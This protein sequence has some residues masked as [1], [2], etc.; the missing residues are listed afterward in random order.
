VDPEIVGAPSASTSTV[1]AAELEVQPFASTVVTL[2]D[3][4]VEAVIDW[5]VSPSDHA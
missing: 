4:L 5:V 2:Y 3:P 1:V